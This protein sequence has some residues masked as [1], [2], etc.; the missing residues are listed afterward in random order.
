M[1]ER[2]FRLIGELMNNSFARARRAWLARDVEAYQRLARHQTELGADYL[3]LNLDGTQNLRILPSEMIDFLPDLVPALQETTT[4]PLSFDNPAYEFHRRA[5]QVYDRSQGEAPILNSVAASRRNLDGLLELIKEFDTMVIVMASEKFVGSDSVQCFTPEDCH[6]AARHFVELLMT[7]AD[8]RLDQ[9]IID[10][11][12]APVAADTYGL[13]NMSLE[14]MRLIHNDPDLSA[15]HI[16]VGLTNFSFGTPP[17]LRTQLE[18]AFLTLA[19]DGGLDFVL[20]NPEK[21]LRPLEKSDPVLGGVRK[22]LKAGRPGPGETQED[23]GFRQAEKI[24]E[25]F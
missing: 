16:S 20:G 10:P 4:L 22:A 5:L 11:G 19:I 9:I 12:L 3:T 1:A 7:K 6:R 24:L 17:L 13:V 8:R 25:L 23:A 18:R 15:V 14:A 21:D 2:P